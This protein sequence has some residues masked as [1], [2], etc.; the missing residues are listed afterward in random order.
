MGVSTSA[1][2]V[3]LG[4]LAAIAIASS[5]YAVW[6]VGRPHPSLSEGATD[7]AGAT[8]SA[9]LPVTAEPEDS[10]TTEA[11]ESVETEEPTGSSTAGVDGW[12]NAWSDDGAALLVIGDGSSNL[13]SQWIHE[14]ATALAD[15]RPVQINHWAETEDVDFNEPD[16]LS[17][18]DG[19]ALTIWNASRGGTTV[20]EAAAH[21][22]AFV[23]AAGPIDAVLVSLGSDSEGTSQDMADALDELQT[24]LDQTVEGLPVLTVVAPEGLLDDEVSDGI[25]TWSQA[26][27]DRVA[28]VDLRATAPEDATAQEWAQAFAEALDAE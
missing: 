9:T 15:D 1:Q 8:A 21:M 2:N 3:L 12:L 23:A 26:N 20:T 17:E 13:R 7:T 27:E 14:W 10:A 5:A 4:G 11:P 25:L 22:S 24:E 16:V 19:P 6:S 18:G 28:L